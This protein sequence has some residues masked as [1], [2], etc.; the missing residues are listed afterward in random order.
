MKLDTNT[1]FKLGELLDQHNVP[2]EDRRFLFA[3]QG[4]DYRLDADGCWC[5]S[6]NR[7][8]IGWT[9]CAPPPALEALFLES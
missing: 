2:A 3:I 6:H 4:V 5:F 1:L 7:D 8:E 9:R